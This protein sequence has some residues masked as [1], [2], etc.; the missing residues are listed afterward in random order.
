[1]HKNKLIFCAL[2]LILPGSGF[3]IIY[4]KGLRNIWAWLHMLALF[5][6]VL[7]YQLLSATE[8]SSALG[9]LM[10]TAGFISLEA[11]WLTTIVYGL[12]PDEKWDAQFNAHSEKKNDSN[13][14][15]V[16]TVILSLM[17]GAAV[18]MTGLAIAFE[19]HFISQYEEAQKISQ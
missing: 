10:A 9:W 11:S 12:R 17:I 5:A 1:M 7:G 6:G 3:N 2:G 8:M 14:L 4:L 19:Q 16:F 13:W 15:V 18:M